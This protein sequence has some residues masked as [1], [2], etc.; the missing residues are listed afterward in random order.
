[1]ALPASP[2]R[3][4]ERLP[5]ITI[6]VA[7]HAAVIGVLL[8][9]APAREELLELGPVMVSLLPQQEP[10]K[11]QQLPKPKP[12]A[13]VAPRPIPVKPQ[14]ILAI[15]E[16]A[17]AAAAAMTQPPPAEP[18]QPSLPVATPAP[19]P[20]T[21]PSFN[22]D[23]LN[24]PAPPYPSL[25]RRLHEEGQ[26]MLR[27]LVDARGLPER[28]EL[29]NSSGHERLD[30]IALETVRHWKFVPARRGEEAV[31]AWVIVP[32]SFSLRS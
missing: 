28:V 20:V 18:P 17:P 2:V 23:Y 1:M 15:A 11:P 29:R 22:A 27:V 19:A 4:P 25:S 8:S 9:Y 7:V 24:N 13:K 16:S 32:I 21:P 10:E 26:V 5:G 30:R 31:S 12:V 3:K 6:T 14:P